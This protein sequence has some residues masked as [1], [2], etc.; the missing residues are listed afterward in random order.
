MFVPGE[1]EFMHRSRLSL[2]CGL[3]LAS[4]QLAHAQT[5]QAPAPASPLPA[6]EVATIKP[7]NGGVVGFVSSPGGRVHLGYASIKMLLHFAYDLP[8]FEIADPKESAN[9]GKYDIDALP[10]DSSP[11]RK[12]AAQ[13]ATP[14]AEQRQMLQSLLRDR[15]GFRFHWETKEGD[16][17]FLTRGTK[18]LRL[19]PPR[20]TDAGW[21]GAVVMKPGGVVDGEA[22]G[23]NISMANLAVLL[24]GDLKIPVIDQTG[25]SGAFDFH[26]D[27]S[28]PDNQDMEAGVFAAVDHLGLKLKR[29][30]GQIRTLVIDQVQ[31]PTEN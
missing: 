12:L 24:G 28:I 15:F 21:R 8:D 1:I 17:Y 16:V 6:F 31:K 27:P 19:E 14:T 30:K 3:L 4:L 18:P 10:P 13:S 29:G 11:S 20:H 2:F 7:A 5:L 9:V 23:M 25:L 26:V 22:F